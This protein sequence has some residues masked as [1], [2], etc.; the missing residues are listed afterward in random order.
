MISQKKQGLSSK[1]RI[2]SKKDFD[3]L[4][5]SGKTLISS[6]KKIK[7]I[8]LTKE[9]SGEG[10]KIAAVVSKKLGKAVWRNRIKRLIKEAYR[11]NKEEIIIAAE[12]AG[13]DLK[14]IFSAFALSEK[15]NKKIGLNDIEPGVLEVV[16]HIKKTL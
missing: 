11:L 3:E 2:K 14:L 1:E 4:Y 10:I 8:Y 9:N 15:K 13:K 16:N 7:A 6:D 12:S 5:T